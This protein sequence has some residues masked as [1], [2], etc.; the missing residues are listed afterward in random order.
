MLD[1]Q[2]LHSAFVVGG[3]CLDLLLELQDLMGFLL[4]GNGTLYSVL[5]KEHS[6]E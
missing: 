2:L 4:P 3:G 5:N 6:N 1:L